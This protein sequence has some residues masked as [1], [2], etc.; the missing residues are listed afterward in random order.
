M[1]VISKIEFHAKVGDN[2]IDVS[3]LPQRWFA[4]FTDTEREPFR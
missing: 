1:E 2:Y 3:H 4:I